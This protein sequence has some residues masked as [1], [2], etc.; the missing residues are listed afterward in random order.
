[1]IR[2]WAGV[3]LAAVVTGLAAYGL[4]SFDVNRINAKHKTELQAQAA[5][6]SGE[7]FTAKAT[8]TKVSYD[9]QSDLLNLDVDR[10]ALDGLFNYACTTTAA[11]VVASTATRHD[12]AAT[13]QKPDER[14]V[15]T[16]EPRRV[17]AITQ[18]GEKYRVQ[19]KAC[20]AYVTAVQDASKGR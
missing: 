18:K 12:A 14:V 15:R 11:S 6:I 17:I 3:A 8:T 2:F 16:F 1:M 5:K 4:H 13:G 10:A 9:L 19:L 20:Q 7:C